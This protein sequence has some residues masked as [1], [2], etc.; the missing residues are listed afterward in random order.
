MACAVLR[1][2][3]YRPRHWVGM[4]STKTGYGT[5]RMARSQ[6][7]APSSCS[8]PC[9][10]Y[11]PTVSACAIS[12]LC[13]GYAV[14]ARGMQWRPE[15]TQP[16]RGKQYYDE[17]DQHGLAAKANRKHIKDFARLRANCGF[18]EIS[19]DGKLERVRPSATSFAKSTAT[20][21]RQLHRLPPKRVLNSTLRSAADAV[22]LGVGPGPNARLPE[23]RASAVRGDGALAGAEPVLVLHAP[24]ARRQ[25]VGPGQVSCLLAACFLA[26][27]LAALASR[28]PRTLTT[29][30]VCVLAVFLPD[31]ADDQRAD[32][33]RIP[34]Q[35][36]P[37]QSPT[38]VPPFEW[39]HSLCRTDATPWC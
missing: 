12:V 11:P 34:V 25:A 9:S 37:G 15:L 16:A 31:S 32:A 14:W 17:D 30:M 38:S 13:A 20:T 26:S 35:R 18:I 6:W 36:R 24:H 21:T 29:G 39:Y 23:A 22:V 10:R 4:R 2:S 28:D 8:S 1:Q 19:R 27:F 5:T 3:P 33:P 7:R